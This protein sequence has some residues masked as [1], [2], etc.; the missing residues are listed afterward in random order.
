MSSLIEKIRSITGPTG[1]L[2]GDEVLAR[3]DNWPPRGDCPAKAV[4]RPASTQE[5]SEILRLCNEARQPVVTHGGVTGLVGGARAGADD[6]ILSLE[7][8]RRL[9][10][11]NA[12]NRSLTV[13]AGATLQ[14]IQQAAEE[15]GF[16]FPLDLGARG[17]ATIGGNISTNAG[18]N[19]VI[20][21]GMTR[22][23]LL[24]IE[25]VLADGTVIS[26]MNDVIKNNTG[27]D[28]K[29]LFVGTEGTLGVVTRAVLRLRPLPRSRNT[30]LVAIDDF[31]RLGRF[32]GQMDSALGGTLS[33]FEVMWNDFYLLVV[34]NGEK[35][36][37]PVGNEHDFYVLIESTG[38]NQEADALRF[39]SALQQAFEDELIVDA[40]IAQSRQ[41]R[42]D[43]WAIRD[44]VDGLIEGSF[45]PLTF[46]VSLSIPD[47][48]QYVKDVKARLEQRWPDYRCATFG[49][50]GDGNIH[51]GIGVGSLDEESVRGGEEIVYDELK[52]RHGVISAEHGI[53]LD[54]RVYL[55]HSRSQEELALMKTL[56]RTMDPANIL[57]RGKIFE[58]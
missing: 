5:V 45:P 30:A 25:A 15:A 41:Q 57:N 8:M 55:S 42:D 52:S 47:M 26:A 23:Q 34:G 36:G 19:S 43:L 20:R 37:L 53:G 32:L 40:A 50:I 17:T 58:L 22:E 7:R 35:H 54:K 33:A 27:Y 4:V 39:E 51:F 14:S 28:L 56:K 49:H 24:G 48:D 11:V 21:Y 38:G 18:G 13:E 3:P 16:L 31:D 9:E 29:Q 44:D 12:V 2:T 10:P 46:D 1:V 6:I